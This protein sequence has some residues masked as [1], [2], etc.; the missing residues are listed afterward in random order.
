MAGIKSQF[1]S[2]SFAKKS[3]HFYINIKKKP[4]LTV[5]GA[6]PSPTATN[7]WAF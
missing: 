4:L 6:A 2:I 1:I 7:G 5:T 3:S